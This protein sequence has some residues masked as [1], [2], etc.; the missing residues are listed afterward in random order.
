M[1]KEPLPFNLPADPSSGTRQG[2]S[3]LKIQAIR[4]VP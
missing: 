2:P 1:K 4:R 3:G